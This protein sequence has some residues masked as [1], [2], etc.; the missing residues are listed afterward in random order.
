[1]S[2]WSLPGTLCRLTLYRLLRTIRMMAR[3]QHSC[4][5]V[6]AKLIICIF[7]RAQH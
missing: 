2:T 3:E 5:M 4:S 1:M 7:L 6:A